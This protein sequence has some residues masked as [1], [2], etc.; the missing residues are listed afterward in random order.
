MAD[1]DNISY[2]TLL[3]SP[4]ELLFIYEQCTGYCSDLTVLP[5]IGVLPSKDIRKKIR[6]VRIHGYDMIL[7]AEIYLI[8]LI[9][10]FEIQ[11]VLIFNSNVEP[12]RRIGTI[13]PIKHCYSPPP[14][15]SSII[16]AEFSSE[17]RRLLEPSVIVRPCWR[18]GGSGG[19][20]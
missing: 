2:Q 16:Y 15:P 8:M 13:F 12:R 14:A 6:T 11:F 18:R 1:W 7:V 9:N 17:E 3:L 5:V 20:C 10:S 19:E 4:T